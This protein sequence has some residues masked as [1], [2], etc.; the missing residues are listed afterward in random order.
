MKPIHIVLRQTDSGDYR[1]ESTRNT[2][3]LAI[4]QEISRKQLAKWD[5]LVGVTYSVA[6]LVLADQEQEQPLLLAK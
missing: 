6:G 4:G 5:S 1:V 2:S 3:Q